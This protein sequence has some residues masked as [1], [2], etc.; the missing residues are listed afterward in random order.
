MAN[1]AVDLLKWIRV[2]RI[3][4]APAGMGRMGRGILRRAKGENNGID[5]PTW[6][7]G[8]TAGK[9]W[10]NFLVEPEHKSTQHNKTS[11]CLLDP[12]TI[13]DLHRF[14]ISTDCFLIAI[15]IEKHCST[16]EYSP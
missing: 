1:M 13:Y 8:L 4:A 7:Y 5:G 9:M 6:K 15:H 10:K 12:P 11:A 16:Y 2:R 3:P 14:R